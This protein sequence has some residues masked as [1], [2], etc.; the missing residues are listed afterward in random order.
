MNGVVRLTGRIRM[1]REVG[2]RLQTA[3]PTIH[4]DP[5][6]RTKKI[7]GDDPAV[8]ILAIDSALIAGG[9]IEVTIRSK[10]QIA[11]IMAG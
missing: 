2:I 10:M 8:S 6:H 7:V 5:Q 9:D 3:R 4:I 11:S 1:D